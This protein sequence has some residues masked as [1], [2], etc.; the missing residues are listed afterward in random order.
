VGGLAEIVPDGQTGFVVEPEALS[1]SRAIEKIYQNYCL[2]RMSENMTTEKRRFS[3]EYFTEQLE[4][5]Y[6]QLKNKN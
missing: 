6:T 5:L 2:Q 4:A 1:I 3:W